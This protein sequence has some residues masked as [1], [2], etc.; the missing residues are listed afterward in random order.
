MSSRCRL[1]SDKSFMWK[2]KW[3]FIALM[4]FLPL[5]LAQDVP[6]KEPEIEV[7]PATYMVTSPK[8]LRR[9]TD[10]E[11]GVTILAESG[12]VQVTATLTKGKVTYTSGSATIENSAV[13]SIP[14][15]TSADEGAY[16][17]TVTGSGGLTFTDSATLT[18]D[19]H[20]VSVFI[21]TDKAIYK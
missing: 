19:P 9:G 5:S 13:V 17:L 6:P 2:M 8:V 7:T 4:G 15:P 14:V 3:I 18:L 11:I 1:M 10:L 21:Q 16:T 12:P 20:S